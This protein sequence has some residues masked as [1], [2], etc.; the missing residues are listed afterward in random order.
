[1]EW[2][3]SEGHCYE[4]IL[5]IDKVTTRDSGGYTLE[6]EN[7]EGGVKYDLYITVIMQGGGYKLYLFIIPFI[8]IIIL[9]IIKVF[10]TLTSKTC[11]RNYK[12]TFL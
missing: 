1:M 7:S 9:L 5:H 10:T 4:A 3:D 6:L 12:A 2:E 8:T 11:Q